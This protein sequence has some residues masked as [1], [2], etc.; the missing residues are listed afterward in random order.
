[1][2]I[3]PLIFCIERRD[4]DVY[5]FHFS[6]GSVAAAGFDEDGGERLDRYFLAVEF[7]LAG[8]NRGHILII[9]YY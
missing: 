4:T 6:C 8:K 2:L 1:V 9:N 7:H 5:D 3:K